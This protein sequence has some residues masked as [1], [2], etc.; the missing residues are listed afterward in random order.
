MQVWLDV[1]IFNNII[2]HINRW[3]KN[4]YVFKLTDVVKYIK[5]KHLFLVLKVYK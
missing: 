1:K 3:N 2:F 5:I 4:N